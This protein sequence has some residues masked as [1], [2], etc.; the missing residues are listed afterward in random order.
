VP[1]GWRDGDQF[2]ARVDYELT[3]GKDRLYGN[4][5]RTRSYAVTGGVRPAFNRPTPNWTTF[6]NVNYTRTFNA[7]KLNEFRGGVMRPAR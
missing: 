3:P 4:F 7:T 1:E 2:S 5:Y 6:G